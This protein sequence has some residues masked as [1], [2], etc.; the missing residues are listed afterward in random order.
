MRVHA[1]QPITIG[2]LTRVSAIRRLIREHRNLVM[3]TDRRM[4]HPLVLL[5]AVVGID[6]APAGTPSGAKNVFQP[7]QRVQVQT[8]HRSC[9]LKLLEHPVTL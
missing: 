6:P 5:D 2:H 7:L 1:P 9:S 3:W 8:P 4:S